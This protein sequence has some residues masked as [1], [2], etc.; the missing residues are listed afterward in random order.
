MVAAFFYVS[1]CWLASRY[2]ELSTDK[3]FSSFVLVTR[4]RVTC[5]ASQV[6]FMFVQVSSHMELTV[7]VVL[8]VLLSSVCSHLASHLSDV[9]IGACC[10]SIVG[11]DGCC[12]RFSVLLLACISCV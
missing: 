6:D 8:V 7:V 11:V 4:T 9:S 1:L 3:C 2:S 12:F 10:A 5:S